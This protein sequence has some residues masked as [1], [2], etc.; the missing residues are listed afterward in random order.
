MQV[1]YPKPTRRNIIVTTAAAAL[2]ALFVAGC[3]KQETPPPKPFAVYVTPAQNTPDSA[4]RKFTAVIRPRVESDL[5]FRVGGKVTARY[6]EIGQSVRAGQVIAR[7]DANDYVLASGAA[8]EQVRAAHADAMQSANDAARFKKLAA[9][10]FLSEAALERQQ[11]RA[12]A[13]AATVLQ[14]QRQLELARNRVAY[15]TLKAPFDGV[16]TGLRFE[17][18]QVVSEGTPIAT[19]ARPNELEVVADIPEEIAPELARYSATAR[20]W[21]RGAPMTLKLRELSPSATPQARTFRARFAIEQSMQPS[22]AQLRIG[23]TLEL[24]LMRDL[25]E[26]SVRLPIAALLKT[27]QSPAVWVADEKRGGLL[28]LPVKI[29]AQATDS[30]RVAGIPDGALIVTVGAQ[31]L[32]SAMTVRPVRRPLEALAAVGD[33]P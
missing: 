29:I 24:R 12:D 18:G 33:R 30:V 1:S 22:I 6:V 3:G 32:D 28:K 8:S 19:L 23:N 26:P 7:I 21:E 16:I 15:A 20:S 31:K 13:S 5:A 9:D 17:T 25:A 2:C 11:A 10:G 14:A 4:E 27:D